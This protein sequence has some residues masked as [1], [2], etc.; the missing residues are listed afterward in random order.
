MAYKDIKD[1]IKYD[2]NYWLKNKEKRTI[3]KKRMVF[4]I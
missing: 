2:R 4:K 1:K 3:Q